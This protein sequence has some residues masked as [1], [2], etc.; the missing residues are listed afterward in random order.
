VFRI[1]EEHDGSKSYKASGQRLSA[2][3]RYWL[4]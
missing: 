4:H 2:K 1:K 3:G